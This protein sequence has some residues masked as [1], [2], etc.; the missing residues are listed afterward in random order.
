M[1]SF[2]G[3]KRIKYRSKCVLFIQKIVRGYLARK[4]HQPRYRGIIKIKSLKEKLRRSTDIRDIVNQGKASKE[5]AI[6]K[7]KNDIEHLIDDAVKNIQNDSRI[8]PKT[9]D[10]MYNDIIHIITKIDNNNSLK[11]DSSIIA[12]EGKPRIKTTKLIGVPKKLQRCNLNESGLHV[13]PTKAVKRL[14]EKLPKFGARFDQNAH[15]P[16]LDS[17]QVRCKLESCALESLYYCKK[18]KVHLCIKQ[19]NCFF[20]FHNLTEDS[21]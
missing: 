13:K 15:F 3:K 1:F 19:K 12:D 8:N 4:Q 11:P 2:T 21:E 18:C 16:A 9:I 20:K 5:V 10:K 14:S 17:K 6:L 7:Q